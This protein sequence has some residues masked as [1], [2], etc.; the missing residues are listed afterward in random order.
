LKDIDLDFEYPKNLRFSIETVSR[1]CKI[2]DRAIEG[3][4]KG[5]KSL[6]S[7]QKIRWNL[8]LPLSGT[9]ADSSTNGV[10]DIGVQDFG[11]LLKNL[12]NL[13]SIALHFK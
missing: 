4:V 7:L 10:T 11:H 8:S 2:G 1:S 9:R 3:L 12:P 13:Q 5:L 6:V